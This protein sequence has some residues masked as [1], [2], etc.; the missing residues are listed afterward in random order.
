[1]T[2][3]TITAEQWSELGILVFC[4]A[5]CSG[6]AFVALTRDF[7]DFLHRIRWHRRRRARLAR[8]RANAVWRSP[9]RSA[10]AELIDAV[11]AGSKVKTLDAF[12]IVYNEQQ[13][14]RLGAALASVQVH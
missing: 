11:A 10:V 2:H 3:L 13:S 1:M 14:E 7:C 8:R 5:V 6:V 9:P 4:L 12:L